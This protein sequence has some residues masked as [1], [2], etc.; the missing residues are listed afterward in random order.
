M[1]TASTHPTIPNTPNFAPAPSNPTFSS[2]SQPYIG[3]TIMLPKPPQMGGVMTPSKPAQSPTRN[4][5][6]S[7]DAWGDF[8]PLA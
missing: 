8:D 6:L 1:N 3:G 5:T 4:N 2:I 7:K